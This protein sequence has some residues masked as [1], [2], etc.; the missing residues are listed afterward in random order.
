MVTALPLTTPPKRGSS[1]C[2]RARKSSS[3]PSSAISSSVDGWTVS[4]R[5]SRRKSACF[6]S[7]TTSTPARASSNAQHHPGRA[8]ARHAA[9]RPQ[10]SRRARRTPLRLGPRQACSA[11]PGESARAN[12]PSCPKPSSSPPSAPR[13]AATAAHSPPSAPTTSPPHAIRALVE[14]SGVDPAAIEDVLWGAANQ[15]GED[16]RNVGRMALLLAGLPTSVSGHDPQPAVRQR[17]AGD[18]LG[19]PRH[20][21]RLRRHRDRRRQRVDD[22]RAVRD[23]QVR[24][25]LRPRAGDPRHD[26]GQPDGQPAAG[27]AVPADFA[28]RDGR[29]RR[30]AVQA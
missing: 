10:P 26:A 2:G 17:P 16:C 15:A 30:R 11:R 8:A 9:L 14:R 20:R 29:E 25:S 21:G 18:Q 24:E 5:K 13:W 7:T 19:L 1:W 22:A 6:S 3:R 27:R 23:P 12:F 4:P 28:R